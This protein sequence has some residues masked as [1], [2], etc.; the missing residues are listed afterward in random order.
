MAWPNVYPR[1]HPSCT[2]PLIAVPHLTPS[3]VEEVTIEFNAK[4]TSVQT[5]SLRQTVSGTGNQAYS[6]WF[7][8]FSASAK[9]TSKATLSRTGRQEKEFTLQVQCLDACDARH[10]TS[11]ST[12]T[13]LCCVLNKTLMCNGVL[14]CVLNCAVL[15]YAMLCCAVLCCAVLCCAALCCAVLCCAALC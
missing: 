13:A 11:T 2:S 12:T 15:C 4:I 7:S 14:R 9:Y 6:A 10:A 1:S 5:T 3:Q 8:R